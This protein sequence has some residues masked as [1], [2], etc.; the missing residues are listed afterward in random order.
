MRNLFLTCALILFTPAC[1]DDNLMGGQSD[2]HAPIDMAN[3]ADLAMRVPNGVMCGNSTCN[4]P[5]V[6]C[7]EP[8]A[9]G[10]SPMCVASGTCVDGGVQLVCDGPEDCAISTPDCCAVAKFSISNDDAGTFDPQGANAMCASDA[11]CPASVNLQAC[12]LHTKLCHSAAD[13]AGYSGTVPFLG[14]ADFTG[15]CSNQQTGDLHFCAPTQFMKFMGMTYY[16][17]L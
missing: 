16:T 15:C 5:Q 4:S 8:S 10:F 3:G 7:F 1:S 6:C 14:A 9:G 17:C 11:D 12:E 13:C 2:M